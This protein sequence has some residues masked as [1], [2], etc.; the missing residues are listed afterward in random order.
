M[1]R[2]ICFINKSTGYILVAEPPNFL[3]IHDVIAI[4]VSH[5]LGAPVI[6]PIAALFTCPDDSEKEVLQILHLGTDIG[7]SKR[8]GKYD[9][10]LG[11]E[12]LPQDAR[13][14]QFLPLRPFYS[15]EIVAWKTGKEG[16]KLRYGRVPEDVRPSAGQA[17]Y[18]FP[19]ETA[20]GETRM[21]LSSQA[22]GLEYGK[23]SS[24]EL[25]QAVHDMLSAAGVRMD[26]EK[27]TLFQ[28]TLTLQDQLKESQV[29]LLMEQEKAE[30]AAREADVAKAAW[31]CRICLNAEVNMTIIPCGHVLCNRCSSS[32][33]RCPFCRT[34]VSRMMRIFR[35]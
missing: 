3:T 17:L 22:G 26:A 18:R 14:V 34:Q 5:R 2:S 19:V 27:E 23:V 21:L 8:E 10:S 30:V 4:V 13:Q 35:P 25:V 1:H 7:V 28:T 20:P 29:A 12:L 32:V 33:S 9:A 31:S 6:L 24:T 11:V 16:E 15:G